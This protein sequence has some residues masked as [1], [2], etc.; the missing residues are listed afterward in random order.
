MSRRAGS[1]PAARC[2]TWD[3]KSD[4]P[5][6]SELDGAA[7]VINLSGAPISLPW[8]PENRSL[9]L[10]S[11]LESS[12]AIGNALS[13]TK[14]P[15]PV[16]VNASAVGYY[17]DR[18]EETLDEGSPPGSGFVADVCKQWEEAVFEPTLAGVRRVAIRAGVAL[19]RGGGAMALFTKLAKFGLGGAAGNGRQWVPWIHLDDLCSLVRWTITNESVSG[20]VNGCSQEPVRNRDLMRAIRHG[21]HRPWAPP[22]PAFAIKALSL[23]GGPDPSL[24]LSS[25]RVVPKVAADAGFEWRY[26]VLSEAIEGIFEF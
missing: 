8:T 1:I 3:G 18:G 6:I 2:V 21:L 7:A 19:G 9:I 16:W 23:L 22:A 12:S 11:R 17:G 10:S 26:P 20:A 15:P 25:Q 4:G 13:L 5:W 24:A 14:S